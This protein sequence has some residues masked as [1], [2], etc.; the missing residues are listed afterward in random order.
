MKQVLTVKYIV[1]KHESIIHKHE[2]L[3]AR[4]RRC[5]L[6]VKVAIA[7]LNFAKEVS[8]LLQDKTRV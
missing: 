2:V 7:V 1:A 8:N 4:K 3:I 5:G 6:W